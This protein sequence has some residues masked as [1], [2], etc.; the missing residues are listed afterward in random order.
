MYRRIEAETGM[1]FNPYQ[2][3]IGIGAVS[4]F[5]ILFMLI[6][7]DHTSNIKIIDVG[8]DMVQGFILVLLASTV[9]SYY[10]WEKKRPVQLVASGLY[11]LALYRLFEIYME[12]HQ[13]Y[14][15]YIWGIGMWLGAA[16]GVTLVTAGLRGIL[17]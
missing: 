6:T 1:R 16:G 14:D 7:I 4:T 12:I 11:L 8:F 3:G 10:H 2:L 5:L 13:N 17:R 9:L 15:P